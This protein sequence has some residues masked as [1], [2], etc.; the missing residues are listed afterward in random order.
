MV[1]QIFALP[2]DSARK[3]VSL[4]DIPG[5]KTGQTEAGELAEEPVSIS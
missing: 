5:R 3:P 2:P 1:L 4:S